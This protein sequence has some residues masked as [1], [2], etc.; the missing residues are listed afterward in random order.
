MPG[1]EVLLGMA[2]LKQLELI[3]RGDSL[4]LRQLPPGG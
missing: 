2:F 1:E 4:T 3:Q